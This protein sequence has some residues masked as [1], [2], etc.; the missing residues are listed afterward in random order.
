MLITRLIVQTIVW[1]VF[2]GALLFGAAGTLAW[3]A[4]WA[5]L[6]E[7][8]VLSIAAGI[9]LAR[10]DPG[11]LV[12]RLSTFVQKAQT[13]W[14]KVFMLCVGVGWCAW[15][16]V[17]GLDGGRYRWS[18]MPP[19]IQAVGAICI[20]ACIG[21][22][23]I[24]FRENS[25]AAPVIKIQAERGHKVIDTGPYAHVRHPMYAGAIPFLLGMPLLLGSWWGLV[26]T[27]ILVGG[28]GVRAVL[29]E[30]MLAAQL[31]GYAEYMQRVKYRFVPFIW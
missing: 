3:P 7:L 20:A 16:V 13:R 6:I 22:S 26:C 18:L 21:F 24:V 12:E 29:E 10:R 1:L 31:P 30:R 17:M 4:A 9:W 19:W 11:L 23:C 5:Y 14:D 8:G 28:I 27:P 15:L 25:F 2:M